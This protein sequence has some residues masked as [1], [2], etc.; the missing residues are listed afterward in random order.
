MP[1]LRSERRLFMF[2]SSSPKIGQDFLPPNGREQLKPA[3]ILAIDRVERDCFAINVRVEVDWFTT[4]FTST[5][6]GEQVSKHDDL[7]VGPK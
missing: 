5:L 6:V 3:N 4:W 1:K 7:R 2:Y